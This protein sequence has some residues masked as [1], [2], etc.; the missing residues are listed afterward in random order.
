VDMPCAS[1]GSGLET[2]PSSIDMA[3]HKANGDPISSSYYSD[4]WIE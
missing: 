3:R 1:S 2:D 4:A